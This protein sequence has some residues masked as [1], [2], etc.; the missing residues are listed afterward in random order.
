MTHLTTTQTRKIIYCPF[1]KIHT[2]L[3][4]VHVYMYTQTEELLSVPTGCWDHSFPVFEGHGQMRP[5]CW[6]W[7][8]PRVQSS[9]SCVTFL[10]FVFHKHS[11]PIKTSVTVTASEVLCGD[12]RRRSIA[13]TS[14]N[15]IRLSRCRTEVAVEKVY[16]NLFVE[17]DKTDIQALMFVQWLVSL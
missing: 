13:L 4:Y 3:L 15:Q 14:V 16:D 2:I 8:S 12:E 17:S 11:E 9:Y 6:T 1:I 10:D 5:T 7:A